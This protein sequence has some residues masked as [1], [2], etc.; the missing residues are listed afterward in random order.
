MGAI[1]GRHYSTV[2]FTF[3]CIALF[4]I[5]AT[6]QAHAWAT[7]FVRAA[8]Q[9]DYPGITKRFIDRKAKDG[10]VIN[11]YYPE[12]GN[13]AIDEAVLAVITKRLDNFEGEPSEESAEE[14][15]EESFSRRAISSNYIIHRP[16]SASLGVEY[17]LC[18]ADGKAFCYKHNLNF[19]LID[20]RLLTL[21]DMFEDPN[22]ALKL[23]SDWSRRTLP[24]KVSNLWSRGRVNEATT[25]T[26]ENFHNQLIIPKGLRLVF[27]IGTVG[28]MAIGDPELD[29]PL[30]E[31]AKAG[32]KP[33]IWGKI[34]GVRPTDQGTPPKTAEAPA[35]AGRAHP[36]PLSTPLQTPVFD[37]MQLSAEHATFLVADIGGNGLN[38]PCTDSGVPIERC[39]YIAPEFMA[40]FED[41]A[42]DFAFVQG[43]VAHGAAA[44]STYIW[45]LYRTASGFRS[46]PPVFV[47]E[48]CTPGK[49]FIKKDVI[50]LSQIKRSPF[51]AQTVSLKF[52]IADGSLKKIN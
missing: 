16:S 32:P 3:F 23:M 5:G 7:D 14:P 13:A 30:K 48:K 42:S 37:K 29:M 31:L 44:Q 17:T 2:I 12:T 46:T 40:H 36:A 8:D 22:L 50:M 33:E 11:M 51:D 25:P 49:V 20:G 24:K 35:P 43:Q 39:V 34:E 10:G 45:G 1:G 4:L 6:T 15:T 21:E 18:E 9:P 38:V 27:D 52:R 19:S 28:P 41:A 26:T 47:C